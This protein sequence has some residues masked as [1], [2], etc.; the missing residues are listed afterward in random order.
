MAN[1]FEKL[2][3]FIQRVFKTSLDIFLEALK[4]SPNAQGYV[5]G[6]ITELLLKKKLEEYGFELKRIKEKWEGKKHPNHHGD[7][8]FRKPGSS[9]Y[10]VLESKGVKS[11]SE[12]WHKLYNLANLRKFLIAHA[13]KIHWVRRDED[14]E[15]QVTAWINANLP[16]FQNEYASN[17]YEYE[18]VQE[19]L[20]NRPKRETAKSTAVASLQDLA[21]EQ[22][23]GMIDERLAYV[24]S[25][26]KVLETHF[27]S[28]TSEI[29]ERTQATP[30]KDEFSI[31]AIDIVLR[32][33]EHKFLLANPKQLESSG[34]DPNHLQQNYIMG[35]VF[36]NEQ[37]SPVLS[38]T[39]E[40]YE[41]F[42]EAYETL[43]PED[44]IREEDMQVDNR[45]VIT[46]DLDEE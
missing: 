25:K 13:D 2:K 29:S 39:E 11:N 14:I 32:Y 19:Y 10:F 8:Y 46:G 21:R 23:S 33:P 31:V 9:H 22:I 26:V 3:R 27:V 38:I 43:N 6:S 37:V 5:L 15:H 17:L 20:R 30:R 41:D 24:M 7:F 40:W 35:F 18:E 28:G 16:K 1:I 12:K 4:L 45:Y 36:S 34:D 42:M 44:S